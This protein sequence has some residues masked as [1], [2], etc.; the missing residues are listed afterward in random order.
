MI[1]DRGG[2]MEEGDYILRAPKGSEKLGA[3]AKP[4]GKGGKTGKMPRQMHMVENV[5]ADAPRGR[6]AYATM[7]G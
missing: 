3:H 5:R 2:R 1:F 7:F 6:G 4:R